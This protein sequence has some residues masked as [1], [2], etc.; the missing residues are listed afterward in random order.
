MSVEVASETLLSRERAAELLDCCVRSV[1]RLRRR[2]RL[3]AVQLI[4]RGRVRYRL[5][6][7]EALLE[8][9]GTRAAPRPPGRTGLVMT[10][11]LAASRNG[12]EHGPG[13]GC[14]KCVGFE[15]G[16]EL[17]VT[18]GATSEAHI[19]P[20]AR[21]HRRRALRQIG[22][23][24]SDLDPAAKAY[25]EHYVRLTAKVVLVDPSTD[26]TASLPRTGEPPPS[27]DLSVRLQP[28]ALAALGKL[29]QH[30]DTRAPSLEK[31]LA[32]LR[33]SA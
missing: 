7:V 24:P 28:A 10:G 23:R 29:A 15:P 9:P 27:T 25:L 12:S 20:L 17:A 4:E 16:N 21:N 14:T 6:D 11:A 22:L 30:L 1:D 8:P 18:H 5:A 33:R 26:A 19:R 2:G 13:C 31:Q 3:P 32:A